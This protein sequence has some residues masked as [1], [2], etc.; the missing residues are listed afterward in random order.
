MK[1][2]WLLIL[3]LLFLPDLGEVV[4]TPF[5]TLE[6]SDFLMAPYL[7]ALLFA[8]RPR[9]GMRLYA[10]SCCLG[11]F[12]GWA[13]V[14]TLLIPWR[15]HGI[16]DTQLE[17]SLLKVGKFTLYAVV[18]LLTASALT[19]RR[20]RHGFMWALLVATGILGVSLFVV[21]DS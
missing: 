4:R 10:A 13:L 16:A 17:F 14:S 1:Y 12:L 2:L 5:G 9:L 11:L 21:P 6:L 19:T 3:P 18:G 7:V 20:A 15:Y 8:A